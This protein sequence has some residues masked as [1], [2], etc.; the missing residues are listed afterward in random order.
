MFVLRKFIAA[1][2]MPLTAALL[3]LVC[4][5]VL[6]AR[7]HRRAAAWTGAVA[8][9]I[10]YLSCLSAVGDALLRPLEQ[11]CTAMPKKL[12]PA[13]VPIVVLGSNY[14]PN[15][16]MPVTA[17]LD[18]EGL[19]RLV[20][21]VRIQRRLPGAQLILSG[22]ARPGHTPAALG[23][24]TLAA[25]LAAP[26]AHVLTAPATTQEEAHLLVPLL[27]DRPFILVT[28]AYH[29]QR[30][31]EEMRRANL[32]PVPWCTGAHVQESSAFAFGRWLPTSAGL[33][34]TERALHEYAGLLAL[35]LSIGGGD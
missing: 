34:K 21:A 24:A 17:A 3:V 12:E 33:R 20:E 23:Y 10:A 16:T 9:A 35:R 19:A 26:V 11:A 6:R 22:G 2:L 1:L 14:T 27:G 25:D 30:A 7:G 15:K 28:S 32:Q 13:A 29:M 18:E 31:L 8:L 4:A 5:V